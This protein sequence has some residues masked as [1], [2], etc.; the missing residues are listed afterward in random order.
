MCIIQLKMYHDTL[1][2]PQNQR[3]VKQKLTGHDIS[4]WCKNINIH[5]ASHQ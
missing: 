2:H 5:R 1:F 4:Q 3:K